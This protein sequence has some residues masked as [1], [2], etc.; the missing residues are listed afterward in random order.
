MERRMINTLIVNDQD[1]NCNCD[2]L[3]LEEITISKLGFV[4]ADLDKFDLIVYK[5]KRGSK[6]IRT[7][8]W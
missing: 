7:K 1:L 5:G 6:V 8:F 4:N 3:T 2:S